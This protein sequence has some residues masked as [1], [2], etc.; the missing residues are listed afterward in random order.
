MP[1]KLYDNRIEYGSPA[2][3]AFALKNVVPTD[4]GTYEVLLFYPDGD[5]YSDT[6]LHVFN[7]KSG[8]LLN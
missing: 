6:L 4:T 5:L 1:G 3:A 8:V 2:F 7:S